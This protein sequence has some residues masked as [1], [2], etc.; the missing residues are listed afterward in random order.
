M[1]IFDSS[2][3]AFNVLRSARPGT[4]RGCSWRFSCE[5]DEISGAGRGTRRGPNTGPVSCQ[6]VS[7]K[8]RNTQWQRPEMKKKTIVAQK[9]FEAT[10]TQTIH[11]GAEGAQLSATWRARLKW[12]S[13]SGVKTIADSRRCCPFRERSERHADKR[14]TGDPGDELKAAKFVPWRERRA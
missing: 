7:S 14:W 10:L 4:A 2:P 11:R 8:F 12:T 5:A 6:R 3:M 9:I 13:T 1:L